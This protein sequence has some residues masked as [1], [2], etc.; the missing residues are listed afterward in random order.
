MFTGN[1][2][3]W[4]KILRTI[5]IIN[6]CQQQIKLNGKHFKYFSSSDFPNNNYIFLFIRYNL[7]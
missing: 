6:L 3:Q 1:K 5:A 2:W 7:Q 4:E